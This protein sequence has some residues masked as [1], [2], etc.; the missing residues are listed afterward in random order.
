MS[1]ENDYHDGANSSPWNIDSPKYDNNEAYRQGV[2]NARNYG[3]GGSGSCFP[4]DTS[5]MTPKGE[6]RIDALKRGDFVLSWNE[7]RSEMVPRRIKRV[8]VHASTL[9]VNVRLDSGTELRVTGN[10][11]VLSNRGW[12]RVDALKSGDALHTVANGSAKIVAVT[13]AKVKENV[14]NLITEGEHTFIAG[15][16]IAHNFTTLRRLRTALHQVAEAIQ[17]RRPEATATKP[18][19]AYVAAR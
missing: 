12:K 16:V 18:V 15:G 1:D 5:I 2:D 3:S 4:G 6:Q 19:A 10:H 7:A 9:P 8:E 13:T 14:F 11:T 17:A